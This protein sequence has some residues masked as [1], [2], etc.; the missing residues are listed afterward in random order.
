MSK[1][2][3]NVIMKISNSQGEIRTRELVLEPSVYE[4]Y[5]E[6]YTKGESYKGYKIKY[7]ALR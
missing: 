6:R 1:K 2:T 5:L 3:Y 4:H 7:L